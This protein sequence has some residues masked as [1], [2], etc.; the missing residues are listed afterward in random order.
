VDA[1]K[2]YVEGGGRALLMVD[3][4]LKLGRSEIADN[5]ALA[6]SVVDTMVAELP[7]AAKQRGA[8]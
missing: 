4:P 2:K 1:I 7:I 3:P 5:D 6:E 8:E